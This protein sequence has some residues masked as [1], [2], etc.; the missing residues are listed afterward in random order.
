MA[1]K[2][3]PEWRAEPRRRGLHRGHPG[4]D[5]NVEL[6]P[7]RIVLNGLEHS[8]RHGEHA[9]ITTGNDGDRAALRGKLQCKP[10]AVHFNS[11]VAGVHALVPSQCQPLHIRSIADNVA[12]GLDRLAGFRRHPL[13]RARAKSDNHDAPSHGRRPLPGARMSEK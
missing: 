3:W 11:V 1:Q 9:R 2:S 7:L 6:D 10:G 8:R 5:G 12:R 13:G 4:L